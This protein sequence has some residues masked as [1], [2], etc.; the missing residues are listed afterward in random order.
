[1]HKGTDF[2]EV[3][4]DHLNKPKDLRCPHSVYTLISVRPKFRNKR[5]E[6]TDNKL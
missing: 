2:K 1:M 4:L 5:L 6:T 3:R